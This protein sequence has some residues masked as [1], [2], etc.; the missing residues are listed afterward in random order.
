MIRIRYIFV[1]LAFFIACN[2]AEQQDAT[3]EVYDECANATPDR[4]IQQLLENNKDKIAP[5][6]T[7]VLKG[8]FLADTSSTQFLMY[9]SNGALYS[10]ESFYIDGA[11]KMIKPIRCNSANGLL[12]YYYDNG[13]LNYTLEMYMGRKHGEGIS[14]Y[15]SGIEHQIRY[16]THDTLD[17]YQYEFFE[18]G[19]TALGRK[20]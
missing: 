10:Y 6:F 18:N 9:F 2:N 17:G 15:P 16:F 19:D 14:Y 3:E 13:T 12:E 8:K 11:L 7:G 1:L 5:G 20:I 4:A